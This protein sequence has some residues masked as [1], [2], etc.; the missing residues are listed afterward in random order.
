MENIGHKLSIT[1]VGDAILPT[2]RYV[3]SSMGIN[4]LNP[5]NITK[6]VKIGRLGNF[7]TYSL[8]V[9]VDDPDFM[10]KRKLLMAELVKEST[11]LHVMCSYGRV[12]D[13]YIFDRRSFMLT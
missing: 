1:I 6:S 2:V 7:K 5:A 4:Q 13:V 12:V 3:L 9:L 11:H 10:S 8:D